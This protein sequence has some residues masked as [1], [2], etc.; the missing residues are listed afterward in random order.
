MLK[1]LY[2]FNGSSGS[3][4]D[5]YGF[6]WKHIEANYT[7]PT[8]QTVTLFF[9]KQGNQQTWLDDI[10]IYEVL[11]PVDNSVALPAFSEWDYSTNYQN[12]NITADK[13]A[14]ASAP[15]NEELDGKPALKIT[16]TNAAAKPV[17]SGSNILEADSQYNITFW[18]KTDFAN[19]ADANQH[20]YFFGEASS[21]DKT[22]FP[23]SG[24]WAKVTI[25]YSTVGKSTN[26]YLRFELGSTVNTEGVV[27]LADLQLIKD[28][29][30]AVN[31]PIDNGNVANWEHYTSASGNPISATVTKEIVNNGGNSEEALYVK[32][33][34]SGKDLALT[35][36]TVIPLK[37]GATYTFSFWSKTAD[38][39]HNFKFKFV[40]ADSGA[41]VGTH[42]A[43]TD[44]DISGAAIDGSFDIRHSG[45]DYWWNW[46]QDTFT[47]D[48]TGADR[49]VKLQFDVKGN[50]TGSPTWDEMWFDTFSMTGMVPLVVV[51][52]NLVANGDFEGLFPVSVVPVAYSCNDSGVIS[53]PEP[54]TSISGGYIRIESLIC[55]GADV[56][57]NTLIAALYKGG[58]LEYM[59]YTV[60]SVSDLSSG[61]IGMVFNLGDL[62]DGDYTLRAFVWTGFDGMRALSRTLNLAE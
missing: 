28:T 62:D 7:S 1:M 41:A 39:Y 22:P 53:N 27:W 16:T 13:N 36:S 5:Y 18:T 50:N 35:N 19:A 34:G 31:T 15:E 33:D 14:T 4:D 61:K 26:L 57:D 46:R 47:F 52:K 45:S 44:G 56:T 10:M 9:V 23:I 12:Q 43:G 49:E 30:V 11:P 58:V 24:E 60:G 20:H 21:S 51:H 37:H 3:G 25:P 42:A 54:I 29:R 32:Y 55:D 40:D 48:Y 59:D 2:E 38:G 6:A 17:Y 8:D